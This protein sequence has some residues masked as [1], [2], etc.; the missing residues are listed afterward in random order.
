M[1]CNRTQEL[2]ITLLRSI[3]STHVR[4]L[5]RKCRAFGDETTSAIHENVH[6]IYFSMC[7]AVFLFGRKISCG[8]LTRARWT[9]F[10]LHLSPRRC[11]RKSLLLLHR[12]AAAA[13]A[14][15]RSKGGH[16]NLKTRECRS[17]TGS[18]GLRGGVWSRHGACWC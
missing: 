11:T 3:C 14:P 4:A 15:L 5:F 18:E 10:R 13:A 12:A 2:N 1:F 6:N 16:R 8:H 9:R 17:T 7:A